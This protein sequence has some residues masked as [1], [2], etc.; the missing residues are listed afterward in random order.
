VGISTQM[1]SPRWASQRALHRRRRGRRG[2]P[3]PLRAADPPHRLKCSIV[4]RTL[5]ASGV[6]GAVRSAPA[7]ESASRSSGKGQRVVLGRDPPGDLRSG[8]LDGGDHLLHRDAGSGEVE[9]ACARLP[10]PA[11]LHERG[12]DVRR[13]VEDA[14]ASE[15]DCESIAHAVVLPGDAGRALVRDLV[16]AVVSIGPREDIFGS[17]SGSARVHPGSPLGA[18]AAPGLQLSQLVLQQ[19][20]EPARPGSR[21]TTVACRPSNSRLLPT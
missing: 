20:V 15:G 21:E 10:L 1:S 12:R 16:D 4:S 7:I 17:S 6:G 14:S 18:T 3:R 5:S 19:A 11:R 8:Q 2:R 9:D 13:V